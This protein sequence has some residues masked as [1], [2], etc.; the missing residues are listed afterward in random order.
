MDIKDIRYF[1]AIAENC[2]M[3]Q[4]ARDLFVSQ[5]A[6]S[7]VVKKLE[8]EFNTKLFIRKGNM[9]TLTAAG[10]HLLKSGRSLLADHDLLTLDLHKISSTKEEIIRFG[11]SSF[12]G[13]Q[14][15]PNLFLY[16][17]K[18]FP[19]IQ[20]RPFETGSLRLEQ[21]VIDR[22]LE[23]CFVPAAPQREEL[24]YR[25]IGVEEFLVAIARNHPVNRYAIASA[26]YPYIEFS[27]IKDFPF[28]LHS[29]G[30]KSS[31]F[32]NRI[33]QHFDFTPNVIFESSSRETVYALTSMGIGASFLPSLM[34][35]MKLPQEAPAFYRISGIDM[36]RNYTVAYRPDKKFTP[37]EEHLINTLAQMVMHQ[38]PD[39][40]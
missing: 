29:K 12:Y 10:E 32:C 14:Y 39:A 8:N 6:L 26:G 21:M 16:Y 36:T 11:L 2:S 20:L 34:V 4:A 40:I 19:S 25:T 17:Q 23:F 31:I 3:S 24:L 13:R 30:S 15:I 18:S 38:E 35:G 22:E 33:F 37:I 9:L 7:L 5:P 1:V 27:H 28:I